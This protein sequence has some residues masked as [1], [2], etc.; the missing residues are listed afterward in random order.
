MFWFCNLS[1]L[2]NINARDFPDAGGALTNKY[3]EV[4]FA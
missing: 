2:T 3:F 4:R 1:K